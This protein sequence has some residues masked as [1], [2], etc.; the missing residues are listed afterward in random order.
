MPASLH[1]LLSHAKRAAQR[2]GQR[3]STAHVLLAM[4]QDD[5]QTGLL[6]AQKGV[7]EMELIRS[8]EA[9]EEE[10]ASAVELAMERANKLARALSDPEPR[11]IHL[12]LAITREPRSAGYRCLEH[13]GTHA[14]RVCEEAL[15]ILQPPAERSPGGA[16]AALRQ[17]RSASPL[18]P[19]APPPRPRPVRHSRWVKPPQKHG[20]DTGKQQPAGK[21]NSASKPTPV[22]ASSAAEKP[23]R[24][25]AAGSSPGFL[26]DPARFPTL[27]SIGR[28]LTLAAAR[29]EID[30]IFGRDREMELVLDVL[31]RRRS[32]NPILVGPP[33]VGKTAVVEGIALKLA[34]SGPGES[35]F[36][37]RV[38][39]EIS[40]GRLISGTGVR[41]A[42]SEKL[43]ALHAEV[44]S[45]RGAVLLFIDEIHALVGLQDNAEGLANELKAFLARGDLPCIGAT[46]ESEYRRLFER[47]AALA[48][49]FTRIDI[50]EPD[51]VQALQ[52]LRGLGPHYEKHHGVAYEPA[53]LEAAVQMSIRYLAEQQLPDKAIGLID[54][55]AARTRRKGDNVVR[56]EAVA[57][58]VSEKTRVPVE[59]LLM[60]DSDRLLALEQHLQERVIGQPEAVS[61]IAPALRK[62]AA[63][64]R[65]SR[66]L[67][68]FLFLGPTGVGKT[69]MAKAINELL[70][71]QAEITRFDMSEFSE[72][73]SVARLLGAPPGYVGHEE[74][75]Q[76]TEAVRSRPYQ[77]ILLDEVDKAH[78]EVLLALLPLLDEGRLMDARGRTVDFT[79]TVIAMT[80]NL[81]AHRRETRPR[82]GFEAEDTEDNRRSGLREQAL[83]DARAALPPELWNRIDEPLYFFPLGK[84]DVAAIA[85]R[86]IDRAAAVVRD[87]HGIELLVHPSVI[88]A[89]IAA[90]GFDPFLGARPMQR[91]VG[92]LVEAPLAS[93]ILSGDLLPGEA[94]RLRGKGTEVLICREDSAAA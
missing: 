25:P 56:A 59:R 61:S 77:L 22:A 15:A 67:G 49:R 30:P 2:R 29:G 74:G 87:Q 37:D 78:P 94:V 76:L 85:R 42:L 57:E 43:H 51:A 92:R 36:S 58:V 65:G 5:N 73:H 1:A 10:P 41:G 18:P 47:D 39:V 84:K 16:A 62:S 11:A 12:L 27:C 71:P 52:I 6:L 13:I 38:I 81:G 82:I 4:L 19:L 79:N 90:G 21:E 28:N 46:T 23:D 93:A 75:G 24:K 60:R 44:S 8:L 91:T 32:N 54:Q 64:F 14:V 88:D 33:G 72:A 50:Q 31:A 9:I 26:L 35:E 69:E 20:N 83:E 63:G 45:T 3:M 17:R 7:R 80:S 86:S 70:F 53:A 34:R 40:V 89:L 68:T 48:R 66:P 55:A